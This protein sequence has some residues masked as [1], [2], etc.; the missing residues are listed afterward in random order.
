MAARMSLDEIRAHIEADS[1]G[2]L[3]V[4]GL[5]DCVPEDGYCTA[6]FTGVYPVAIPESFGRDK[7]M[8]GYD[9]CNLTESPKLPRDVVR[10]K[11]RDHSWEAAH[12]GA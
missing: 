7:F 12:P 8:P 10:A 2:F 5:L 4:E 9:P 6:C 11:D 1:V 3:S